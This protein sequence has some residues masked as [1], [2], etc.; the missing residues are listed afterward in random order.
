MNENEITNSSTMVYEY[1]CRLDKECIKDV[2]EQ[3][4]LAHKLYNELIAKIREIRES[5]ETILRTKSEKYDLVCRQIEDMNKAFKAAKAEN[6]EDRMTEVRATEKKLWAERKPLAKEAR[7]LAK[8]ELKAL[9]GQIGKNSACVTYQ[10]TQK[11]YRET[12]LYSENAWMT[13][14]TALKAWDKVRADGGKLSFRIASLRTTDH[15]DV[16]FGKAGGIPV[17]EVESG[18]HSLLGLNEE[19][20][21][22][23]QGFRFRISNRIGNKNVFNE[24]TGT[25]QKHRPF[26]EG[27]MLTTTRL[28][29]KRIGPN[30]KWYLQF[31][32]KCEKPEIETGERS[33]LAA[34]HFGWNVSD[35][36]LRRIAAVATHEDPGMAQL[37]DLPYDL[38]EDFTRGETLQHERDTKRDTFV[39]NAL[40]RFDHHACTE[41]QQKE[42]AALIKLPTQHVAI[43][44]L[45]RLNWQLQDADVHFPELV[46]FSKSDWK[47]YQSQRHIE[48]RARNRRKKMYQQIALDLVKKHET[49]IL[50]MPD[51]KEAALRIDGDGKRNEL[52][53]MA[54]TARSRAALF[55]FKSA[56]QWA[57]DRAGT[58]IITTP[59]FTHVKECAMCG[60][61]VERDWDLVTCEC[62]Y[63]D[64]TKSNSA[65]RLY[66]KSQDYYRTEVDKI[67]AEAEKKAQQALDKQRE[68]LARM[69]QK[70]RE[71]RAEALAA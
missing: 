16:R 45:V 33:P 27:A 12:G 53:Q 4:W 23:Y 30:T 5:A 51:L 41:D 1:G 56:L 15:I 42:I 21:G 38:M 14:D 3:F 25:W 29:R 65:A 48:K 28:V 40:P 58:A 63:T 20:T 19:G 2:N 43:S 8:E 31:Q 64:D 35:E 69:Q 66:Q 50:S 62:G 9:Y 7:T 13:M 18:R 39:T 55:E 44:R 54:R 67:L 10:I 11:Y 60:Q 37:I 36:G 52:G 49:I 57:A 26:P 24:A 22:K 17:S 70:R 71:N 34:I 61:E 68:K 47:L 32:I 6:D 46:A 59:D